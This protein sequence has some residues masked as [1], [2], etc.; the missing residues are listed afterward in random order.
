VMNDRTNGPA[1]LLIVAVFSLFF[2]PAVYGQDLRLSGQPALVLYP[3]TENYGLAF[4]PDS[5]YLAV[6][7]GGGFAPKIGVVFELPGGRRVCELRGHTNQIKDLAFT[8]D[9][10]RIITGSNDKTIRVWNAM[11]GAQVGQMINTQEVRGIGCAGSTEFVAAGGTGNFVTLWEVATGAMRGRLQQQSGGIE[12][13]D[14]SADGR[15]V[16]SAG[17]D[18]S[19][20]VWDIQKGSMVRAL[21]G[22]DDE[23]YCVAFSPDMARMAAGGE[24][25]DVRQWLLP[26]FSA[27]GVLSG[28][29]NDVISVAYSRDGRYLAS[30]SKDHK[31][32]VW[33][34]ASGQERY[35]RDV[36]ADPWSLAFSPDGQFLAVGTSDKGV[37]LFRLDGVG[38]AVVFARREVDVD[39][40][41]TVRVD[42]GP[43]IELTAPDPGQ[44]NISAPKLIVT[45]LVSDPQGI[46]RV[47]VNGLDA[48]LA[49]PSPEDIEKFGRDNK[50]YRFVGEALL[51]VGENK[52]QIVAMDARGNVTEKKIIVNRMIGTVD[53]DGTPR[54][55]TT[56]TTAHTEPIG[57]KIKIA[58]LDLDA[59]GVKP[60]VALVLS[61]ALRTELYNSGRF[62]VMNRK[63][64]DKVL[65]EKSFEATSSVSSNEKIA[66]VGSALGVEK[67]VTGSVGKLGSTFMVTV[68]MI[69]VASHENERIASER[70]RGPEDGLFMTVEMVARKL[71]AGY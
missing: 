45:G 42:N 29:D 3:G 64:V 20:M 18:K 56:T 55:T 15:L 54:I 32:I 35:R 27:V 59:Q 16:V 26:D 31:V 67:M 34:A 12:G 65:R 2:L 39:V 71:I 28:H 9:G 58:V 22:G 44:P 21:G 36:G 48:R 1:F 19:L 47:S 41:R 14:M 7:A 68:R 60:E 10:S 25:E 50:V 46:T 51:V 24:E 38:S 8:A 17:K 23:L 53:P 43:S 13:V 40:R 30:G 69:D 33:D 5:R 49:E 61:E 6:G 4:S 66:A 62:R 11:T 70:H 52:V 37:L 63:D 57:K